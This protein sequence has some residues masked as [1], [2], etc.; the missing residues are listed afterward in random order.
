MTLLPRDRRLRRRDRAISSGERPRYGFTIIELLVV[1]AIISVLVALLLPVLH[2]ARESS[3]TVKCQANLRSM[4]T[5]WDFVLHGQRGGSIPH[6]RHL[7]LHTP[8]DPN[9][10]EALDDV[11]GTTV[12]SYLNVTDG[13]SSFG[14]FVCPTVESL[15]DPVYY[16][17]IEKYGYPVNTCWQVDN[18]SAG[19]SYNSLKN[20]EEIE[21]PSSYPWF[22]DGDVFPFADGY[23]VTHFAPRMPGSQP[24]PYFGVGMHHLEQKRA[25]VAM[26]DG[27]VAVVEQEDILL[28]PSADPLTFF[29]AVTSQ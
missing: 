11:F 7:N 6:T 14:A 10:V 1:I 19:F 16:A 26:G 9:W 8:R 3:R 13:R 4:V 27:H 5:A 2:Q 28:S 25:N 15:Y 22:F 24:Y 21:Q 23:A 17:A 20:A 12:N 18:S 29:Q